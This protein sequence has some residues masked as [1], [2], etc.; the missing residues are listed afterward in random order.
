MEDTK[1]I[2]NCIIC[3]E[4]HPNDRL[5]FKCEKPHR[6]CAVCINQL[7]VKNTASTCPLCRAEFCNEMIP[8][9]SLKDEDIIDLNID[10]IPIKNIFIHQHVDFYKKYQITT[11][12]NNNDTLELYSKNGNLVMYMGM[13]ISTNGFFYTYNQSLS[14]YQLAVKKGKYQFWD[15]SK[16]YRF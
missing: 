3:L 7:I 2:Y 4:E 5:Y 10:A 12:N 16:I 13:F 11:L 9:S 6:L 14:T 15:L 8:P 1:E